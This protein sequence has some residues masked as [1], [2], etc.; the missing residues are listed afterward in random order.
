MSDT[1]ETDKLVS[2]TAFRP[3]LWEEAIELAKKLETQL[4]DCR[5]NLK[6]E[7]D[8][9]RQ[10]ADKILKIEED[11]AIVDWIEANVHTLTATRWNNKIIQDI[12]EYHINGDRKSILEAMKNN[13]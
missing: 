6:G 7:A 2:K 5:V 1:P 10:L 8:A 9:N 13:P 12:E 11:R 3:V 4:N